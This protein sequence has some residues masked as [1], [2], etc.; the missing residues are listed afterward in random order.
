MT[1]RWTASGLAHVIPQ[2]SAFLGNRL[3]YA[4][5]QGIRLISVQKKYMCG[6][7]NDLE[8]IVKM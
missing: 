5:T 3:S 6:E 2:P 4:V 7:K 8:M 1:K